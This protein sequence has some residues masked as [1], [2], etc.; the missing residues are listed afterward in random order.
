MLLHVALIEVI[1]SARPVLVFS[2]H[3]AWV[4]F[5]AV[6]QLLL[7]TYPQSDGTVEP[8]YIYIIYYSGHPWAKNQSL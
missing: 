5:A 1:P 4:E 2:T 7:P 8:A 6:L 3:S